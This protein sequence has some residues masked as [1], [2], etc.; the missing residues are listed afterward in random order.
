M[1]RAAGPRKVR[2]MG[3]TATII[4]WGVIILCMV[5]YWLTKDSP[6]DFWRTMGDIA[7]PSAGALTIIIA[8]HRRQ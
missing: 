1:K 8:R 6:A 4:V 3:K 7:V 2:V 5:G